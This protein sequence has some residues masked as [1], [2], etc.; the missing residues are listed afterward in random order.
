VKRLVSFALV[1]ALAACGAKHAAAP[2]APYVQTTVA[3]N[4]AVSPSSAM[5]GLIAPF[6]NAA[7]Q[8]TLVEPA[9]TVNVQEGDHVSKGQLLAQLD[10]ADLQA[11]LQSDIATAQSDAANTTH[12]VFSGNESITQGSQTLNGSGRYQRRRRRKGFVPRSEVQPHPALHRAARR[13]SSSSSRS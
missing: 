13:W 9:D 6:E 5:S 11:E 10:T 1:A 4:G 12:T 3:N 2:P 8:T 7:I